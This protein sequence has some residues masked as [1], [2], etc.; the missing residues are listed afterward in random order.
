MTPNT[1]ESSGHPPSAFPHKLPSSILTQTTNPQPTP[2]ST[3]DLLILPVKIVT[4][5]SSPSPWPS[6]APAI[7]GRATTGNP[8]I[9]FLLLPHHRPVSLTATSNCFSPSK[10]KS[11]SFPASQP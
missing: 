11:K 10:Q 3:Q 6:E 7:H 9:V 2:A 8:T 1:G 4:F 5:T